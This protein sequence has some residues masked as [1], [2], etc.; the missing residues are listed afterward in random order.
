MNGPQNAL[1]RA[2]PRLLLRLLFLFSSP[3][4]QAGVSGAIYFSGRFSGL[5]EFRHQPSLA[6]G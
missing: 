5:P 1:V 3:G 6:S 4:L 2:A